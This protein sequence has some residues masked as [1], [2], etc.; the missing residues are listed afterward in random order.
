MDSGARIV[1]RPP[2]ATDLDTAFEVFASDCYHSPRPMPPIRSILD[3]GANVG[4]SVIR[5]L[6]RY[7]D[8]RVLAYEPHPAHCRQVREHIA[9]NRVAD[10]VT[11]IEA[12]AGTARGNVLLSDDENRSSVIGNS[13]GIRVPVLDLFS[14]IHDP[15][16]LVKIDIEGAE[17]DILGDPRFERLRPQAFVLE[18]HAVPG[19]ASGPEWCVRRFEE[20]RYEAVSVW[21]AVDHGIIWAFARGT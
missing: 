6:Y 17:Y 2:P 19:A 13:T 18:W 7:P 11:L 5:W 15:F 9:L 1:V 21:T 3:L 12:A 4:Y 8:A 14:E 10:R 20:L 16:D